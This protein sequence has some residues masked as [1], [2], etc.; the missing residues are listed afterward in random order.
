MPES[1]PP[2]SSLEV[3]LASNTLRLVLA[4]EPAEP[5]RAHELRQE[6]QVATIDIG[7]GGRLI[8]IELAD[9]YIDVMPPEPDTETLIR[10][11]DADVHVEQYAVDGIVRSLVIPRRGEGYEITYPSGNQ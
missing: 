6:W 1:I 3:D 8:G 11:S 4:A 10:S 5:H 7:T 9:G 2:L